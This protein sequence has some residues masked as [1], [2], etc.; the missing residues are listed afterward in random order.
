MFKSL[1]CL[2]ILRLSDFMVLLTS[3][4]EYLVGIKRSLFPALAFL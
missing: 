3:S 1:A 2:T 4:I